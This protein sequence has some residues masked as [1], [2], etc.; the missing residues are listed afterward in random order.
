M[1][2]DPR[3]RAGISS[4][5]NLA[6]PEEVEHGLARLARDVDSGAIDAVIR[7]SET[8]RGEYLVVRASG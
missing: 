4:F 5:A 6:P 1:Y 8:G 2:L 3:V 7:A